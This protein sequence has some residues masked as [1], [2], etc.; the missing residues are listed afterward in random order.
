MLASADGVA[1]PADARLVFGSYV[2]DPSRA[3]LK[4]AGRVIALRRKAFDLLLALAAQPGQVLGKDELLA[5]VWPGVVVGEDSLAQCVHELRAA[6]GPE[7]AAYVRTVLR[8]GYRFDAD[9]RRDG[10]LASPGEAVTATKRQ[11]EAP[12]DIAAETAMRAPPRISRRRRVM[13]A[14]ALLAMIACGVAFV[15]WQRATIPS[16]LNAPAR[17]LV[18]LPLTAEEGSETP[19]WFVDALTADL[20]AE[21]GRL[22]SM[23]VI[24]RDTAATWK[25]KPADPRE[26]AHALGVRYVVRG[27][28]RRD[29]DQ[30]RLALAM[31]DGELG[32]EPWAN[33]FELERNRLGAATD[34]VVQQIARQL[35]VQMYRS[36]ASRAAALS[37]AQVQADDLA[38]QGWGFFFRGYTR[39]N[40]VAALDLFDQAVSRDPKSITGWGGVAVING[41]GAGIGWLPDRDA[42]VS[43]LEIASSQL[44]ALD[45]EH[46]FALLARSNLANLQR[47]YEAF[48]QIHKMIIARYPSH[49]SSYD[50][51]GLGLINLGRFDDAVAPIEKAIRLS[52]RDPS[53]G[54]WYWHIGTSHFMRGRYVDAARFA[55]IAEEASP[56]L[57]LPP[58]LRA[59]SLA[60]SGRE[61][62]ARAI[63][64]RYRQQHPAYRATD[65]GISMRSDHPAYA[66]GRES[67]IESLRELGLP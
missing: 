15:V 46:L 57:P 19:P 1:S 42:A 39:E 67:M 37:P 12:G 50:S 48:V 47:D 60:R 8:R 18:L 5:A 22:P 11:H 6:L 55:L 65:I 40:F 53:R 52:P 34:D 59:A 26:V 27:S 10:A 14:S 25:G 28:V 16:A 49:A 35:D 20:T 41:V 44:Q 2:L 51:L 66:A 63:V 33:R 13:A 36:N 61:E 43:R 32:T 45:S 21:L 54:V 58:L 9:V 31:A 23:L 64:A 56:R 29:G 24:A 62:E 7:G 17:S 30:V 3:E 4:Q 38:M